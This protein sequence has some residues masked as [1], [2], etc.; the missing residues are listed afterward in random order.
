MS[1]HPYPV[2]M[3]AKKAATPRRAGAPSDRLVIQYV[4]VKSIKRDPANPRTI[5]AEN[6][7]RLKRIIKEYGIVEPFV[8]RDEDGELVGGH[9]RLEI[10]IELGYSEVPVIRR[11]GLPKPKARALGVALN[12][13]KAQGQF[14][15]DGL[16][17]ILSE[18]DDRDAAALTGF[19]DDDVL[20]IL[21]A[22]E[23]E[24]EVRERPEPKAP[25]LA[26]WLISVPLGEAV[27]VADVIAQLELMPEVTTWATVSSKDG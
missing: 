8:L 13:P 27:D 9:Q 14:V 26:W 17:A 16:R 21:T 23:Q 19:D 24:P 15:E 1:P 25:E 6:R 3:A 4:D 10:A 11:K 7:A 18:L 20:A 2:V 12:N 22:E 5:T